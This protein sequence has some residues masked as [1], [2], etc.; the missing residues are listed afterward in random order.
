MG[1]DFML[2][3]DR[4]R[5]QTAWVGRV[6]WFARGMLVISLDAGPGYPSVGAPRFAAEDDDGFFALFRLDK[7]WDWFGDPYGET[8]AQ[9]KARLARQEEPR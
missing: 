5:G 3:G 2:F 1:L 7:G 8:A 4:V 6:G 9:R